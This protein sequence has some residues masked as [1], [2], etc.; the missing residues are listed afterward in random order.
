MSV[1]PFAEQVTYAKFW[2][3]FQVLA[4]AMTTQDNREGISP[5]NPNV[6]AFLDCFFTLEMR[7][8]KVIEFINLFQGNMS[9]KE[10][11]LKF[12]QFSKYASTMVADSRAR[13]SS[14]NVLAPMFNKYKVSNAKP[15]G[16][17]G[18]GS[19]IPASQK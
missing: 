18:S 15:Q 5:M 12:N 1:N 9:V 16:G 7:E 3:T 8:V 4:Q 2:T 13:M 6:G 17:G 11:V 14:S 19:S 10:Y